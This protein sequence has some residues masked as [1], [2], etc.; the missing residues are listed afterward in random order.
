ERPFNLVY[1]V[2]AKQRSSESADDGLSWIANHL[3]LAST[4]GV[5][6]LLQNCQQTA[7]PRELKENEPLLLR[8]FGS[9]LL[10]APKSIQVDQA[11][12]IEHALPKLPTQ[13]AITDGI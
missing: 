7:T 1:C 8:T 12:E 2:P 10:A 9:A 13:A 11:A 4:D 5:R 3:S 6:Q